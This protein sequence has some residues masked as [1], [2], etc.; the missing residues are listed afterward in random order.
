M[1]A[2]VE[3]RP[4]TVGNPQG[5]GFTGSHGNGLLDVLGN[6]DAASWPGITAVGGGFRGGRWADGIIYTRVSD[7]Y[8]AALVNINRNSGIGGRGV[9]GAP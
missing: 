3:E 9:R 5:R 1:T 8:R 4:V 6:T 2:N 7:R